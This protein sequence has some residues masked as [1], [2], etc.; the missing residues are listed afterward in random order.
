MDKAGAKCND[1]TSFLFLLYQAF[2]LKTWR[3]NNHKV[4]IWYDFLNVDIF[5]KYRRLGVK[6]RICQHQ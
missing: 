5:R 6:Y 4:S 3:K 2:M 1:I